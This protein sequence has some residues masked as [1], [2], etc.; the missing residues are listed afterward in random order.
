LV[1]IYVPITLLMIALLCA[2]FIFLRNR[3][4]NSNLSSNPPINFTDNSNKDIG[5]TKAIKENSTSNIPPIQGIEFHGSQTKAFTNLLPFGNAAS[6]SNLRDMEMEMYPLETYN[7]STNHES[8]VLNSYLNS[9]SNYVDSKSIQIDSTGNSLEA[10]GKN[11]YPG[12][13]SS[14]NHVP[15]TLHNYSHAKSP[16][17]DYEL[18][19]NNNNEHQEFSVRN[20]SLSFSV[21]KTSDGDSSIYKGSLNEEI[22]SPIN[23]TPVLF[24]NTVKAEVAPA[25][26]PEVVHVMPVQYKFSTIND[27]ETHSLYDRDGQQQHSPSFENFDKNPF[28]S[29]Y[30]S[31]FYTLDRNPE[32]D[33]TQR[34]SLPAD[35]CVRV[36]PNVA[37]D[38]KLASSAIDTLNNSKPQDIN[39]SSGELTDEG[40]ANIV[41]ELISASLAFVALN[42]SKPQDISPP[43]NELNEVGKPNVE[44][45]LISASRDNVTSSD[46][47]SQD[48][49]PPSDELHAVLKPTIVTDL[50]STSR[51]S[52]TSNNSKPQYTNSPLDELDAVDHTLAIFSLNSILPSKGNNGT[53]LIE[54]TKGN[55]TLDSEN[56]ANHDGP[57]VDESEYQQPDFY[58]STTLEGPLPAFV[59]SNATL[60]SPLPAL[61]ML[62]SPQ[63]SDVIL[64]QQQISHLYENSIPY[65]NLFRPFSIYSSDSIVS[66][67][68]TKSIYGDIASILGSIQS[69]EY[70]SSDG[71]NQEERQTPAIQTDLEYH[72]SISSPTPSLTVSAT[73]TASAA[74][75][76]TTHQWYGSG[77]PDRENLEIFPVKPRSDYYVAIR[78]YVAI[79]EDELSI[80]VGDMV[81]VDEVFDDGW[82]R[83]NIGK[84][85]LFSNDFY[86]IQC[87]LVVR[88]GKWGMIPMMALTEF[89]SGPSRNRGFDREGNYHFIPKRSSSGSLKRSSSGSVKKEEIIKF[90]RTSSIKHLNSEKK[91]EN[92]HKLSVLE[93]IKRFNKVL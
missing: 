32:V 87:L 53:P 83:A 22:R 14:I 58:E 17:E 52:V 48:I 56:H 85:L 54:T 64:E 43:S 39:S 57:V 92:H 75:S 30:G 38:L 88:P 31:D 67:V 34:N 79:R 65:E 47:K 7:Y 59:E 10:A 13:Q 24:A 40:K 51:D 62:D 72:Q 93:K 66:S 11:R 74:Q 12:T 19:S 86:L 18:K 82:A 33:H 15:L 69:E 1:V 84:L 37:P 8:A 73:V 71:Q 55:S 89:K 70:I 28:D 76:P 41:P 61:S 90:E 20:D 77:L 16:R 26:E 60:E 35:E 45:D 29:R 42:N 9:T 49:I 21:V 80:E 2:G 36:E 3:R 44:P 4:T 46:S 6:H 63:T 78:R 91:H 23:P 68:K 50:I 25:S 81:Q 27:P 5:G